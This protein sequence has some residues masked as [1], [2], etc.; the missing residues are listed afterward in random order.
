MTLQGPAIVEDPG[1]TIVIHPGN[2][3]EIDGYGN[4]HIHLAA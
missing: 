2:T 4:I 3:V 1:T